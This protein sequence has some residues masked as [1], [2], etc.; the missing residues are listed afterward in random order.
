M[1]LPFCLIAENF[2]IFKRGFLIY[3]KGV[4]KIWFLIFDFWKMRGTLLLKIKTL[5]LPLLFPPFW[6]VSYLKSTKIWNVAMCETIFRNLGGGQ[7][8]S[9]YYV[10]PSPSAS[11][12]WK[13]S[14]ELFLDCEI[15]PLKFVSLY[16]GILTFRFQGIIY[17]Y[18]YIF[19]RGWGVW[20]MFPYLKKMVLSGTLFTFSKFSA[21]ALLG[22]YT[23]QI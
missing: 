14:S 4:P 6:N 3:P 2:L 16:P 15:W 12:S 11:T 1:D 10:K 22:V 18:I 19:W 21:F 17:I 23:F 20:K 8:Y 5:G 13:R 9:L 7:R